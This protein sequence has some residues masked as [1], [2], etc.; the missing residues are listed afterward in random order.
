MI[1]NYV[2]LLSFALFLFALLYVIFLG[3]AVIL[4]R[5]AKILSGGAS[6]G[7]DLLE[8]LNI[9]SVGSSSHDGRCS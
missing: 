9:V 6:L 7:T 5:G 4:S 8:I 2:L 1:N 3:L